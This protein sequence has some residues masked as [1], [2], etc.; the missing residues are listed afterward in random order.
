VSDDDPGHGG[1]GGR[2]LAIWL[3]VGVGLGVVGAQ[4]AAAWRSPA[5]SAILAAEAAVLLVA[6]LLMVGVVVF[7]SDRAC[8][9]VFRLLRWISGRAEPPSPE[10]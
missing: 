9:R 1:V 4:G 3:R 7:G 10:Q 5:L 8:N 2:S 6:I